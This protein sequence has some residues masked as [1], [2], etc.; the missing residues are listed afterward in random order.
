MVGVRK[1]PYEIFIYRNFLGYQG[2]YIE[3]KSMAREC[4]EFN[5]IYEQRDQLY[6][7]KLSHDRLCQ[8]KGILDT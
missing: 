4:I 2:T 7:I 6:E 3:C 8:N 1:G 5:Q